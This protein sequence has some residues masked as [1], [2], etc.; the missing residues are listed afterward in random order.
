MSLLRSGAV[1]AAF[2]AACSTTP[3]PTS[4][5]ATT[6]P[7]TSA[8]SLVETTVATVAPSTTTSTAPPTTTTTTTMPP[9]VTSTVPAFLEPDAACVAFAIFVAA[10]D[11]GDVETA[12][13]LVHP[14][15]KTQPPLGLEGGEDRF[16]GSDDPDFATYAREL[17]SLPGD[18]CRFI[19][20]G[21]SFGSA[22]GAIELSSPTSIA[23][24]P[25]RQD[26]GEWR[27]DQL[28]DHVFAVAPPEGSIQPS[29]AAPSFTTPVGTFDFRMQVDGVDV[30]EPATLESVL[31]PE[32]IVISYAP[33]TGYPSG[34]HRAVLVSV[35]ENGLVDA[36]TVSWSV[37]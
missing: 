14:F 4:A 6:T 8:T 27:I 2:L 23:A 34:A 13:G 21:E 35:L 26:E 17:A 19:T 37:P 18:A 12:Y 5:P 36:A 22:I 7:T 9:P 33:P 31:D 20:L 3:A 1:I 11:E 16:S 29:F 10:V 15:S 28:L 25:V 32:R 24:I 30:A